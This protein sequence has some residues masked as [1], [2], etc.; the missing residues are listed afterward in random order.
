MKRLWIFALLTF[1]I[2]LSG[3]SVKEE[4]P[5]EYVCDQLELMPASY[6][7]MD[8]PE[9]VFLTEASDEGRFAI[10]THRDY[11]IVQ[12][13][14]SAKSQEAAIE[15]LSGKSP[16]QLHPLE[17]GDGSCRF[18]WTAAGEQGDLACSALLMTDGSYYYSLCIQCSVEVEKEYRQEF[19]QI[20]SSAS[21]QLV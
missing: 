15:Y 14:F 2:F 21:L 11:E 13:V 9:N 5:V 3:C 1:I 20:L 7:T 16:E 4:L 19:S 17:L 6:L 12:E 10:F 18:A 8:I